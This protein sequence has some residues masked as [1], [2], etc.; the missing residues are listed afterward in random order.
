VV[1]QGGSG[2]GSC[3]KLADVV[4]MLRPGESETLANK[5][6]GSAQATLLFVRLDTLGDECDPQ[7]L[8]HGND[9]IHDTGG[10]LITVDPGDEGAV[11]FY[12]VR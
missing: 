7:R 2:S 6:A 3:K 4:R 10:A 8:C 1:V 11:Y 12:C 9:G 5:A